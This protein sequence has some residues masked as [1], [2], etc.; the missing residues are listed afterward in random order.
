MVKDKFEFN[1]ETTKQEFSKFMTKNGFCSCILKESDG[2][3]EDESYQFSL[4]LFRAL[5]SFEEATVKYI[6]EDEVSGKII[7]E[8]KT[9]MD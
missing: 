8:I 9:L 3:S 5:K 7:I 2:G 6:S 1:T 4:S